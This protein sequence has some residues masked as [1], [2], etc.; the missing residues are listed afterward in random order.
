[1]LPL[2]FS[3][4][5]SGKEPTCHCRGC[6]TWVWSLCRE[7]PLEKGM[8]THSC[9]CL[10]NP[11]DRGAWRATVCRV[12]AYS[13][14]WLIWLSMLA[15]SCPPAIALTSQPTVPI[16]QNLLPYSPPPLQIPY[17]RVPWS[18]RHT[19]YHSPMKWWQ[20]KNWNG[21]HW[22]SDKT[23]WENNLNKSILAI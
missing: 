15:V 11:M 20:E 22:I 12:I 4:S 6:V 13:Q 2:D 16:S 3:G 7:D 18:H 10:E 19:S 17:S 5:T 8:A 21:Y 23:P 14:T 1:M 9:S